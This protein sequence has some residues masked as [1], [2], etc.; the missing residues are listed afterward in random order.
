MPIQLTNDLDK[1][2]FA[3]ALA[4]VCKTTIHQDPTV[5]PKA[6]ISKCFQKS[7]MSEIDIDQ[8]WDG[9]S[10]V[11]VTAARKGWTHVELLEELKQPDF[12]SLPEEQ[13][14]VFGQ[15]WKGEAT[16]IRSSTAEATTFN[17]QLSHF[18][19]RIDVKSGGGGG[20]G[21]GGSGSGGDDGNTDVPCALLEMN[22]ADRVSLCCCKL[23]LPIM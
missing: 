23:L 7:S 5:E 2:R 4:G 1:K 13:A 8:F 12:V 10:K 17:H 11:M 16:N 14:I 15:F 18:T 22:V 19:W 3:S 20:G 6:L 21:G 9:L